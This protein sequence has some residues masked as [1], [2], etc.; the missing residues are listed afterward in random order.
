MA[1]SGVQVAVRRYWRRLKTSSMGTRVAT[2][3]IAVVVI[4][5]IVFGIVAGTSGSGSSSGTSTT[6][7]G[8]GGGTGVPVD[9]ASTSTR[10][11]TSNT[12]TVVF[13]VSNLTALSA[14][15][16]F[17]GDIEYREQ[18]DAINTFV[19]DINNHGGIN[20]RKIVAQIVPFDPTSESDMRARCKDWTE[21]SPVFAV[22]DGLGAWTGDNELCVTQEGSTPFI[23]QWTTVSDWTQ[24]GSPYLWW[25]GPDQSVILR[26]LVAW[27]KSASLLGH[28][29]RVGVVVGDRASDQLALNKY[30][31][32][33]FQQA[34]LPR[35]V[36]QT[37]SA[38]L[39][40][41]A[42]I[43][44]EAPLV[45]QRLRSAGVQSVIP[46]IPFN[47]F[48]PYL[49]AE[50]QQQYFPRLL[51]SDYESTINIALGLIPYPYETALDGQL[52][53]SVETLG[54]IDDPR[55]ESQ[56]GYDAGV[57]SCWDTWKQTH[58]SPPAP[59]AN[60]IE[61]QGPVVSWC[62]AVRLFA[63]AATKAG[64]NLNRRSFVQ[65]LSQITDFPGTLTPTMTFGPNK[66]Y[67]PVEYRVL[68]I[69]N[70]DPNHNACVL[71]SDGTPQGT[72]W[73]IVQDYR[74]LVTG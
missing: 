66:F 5:G 28:G 38:S 44:S 29:K 39:T 45:V 30:L 74:P 64:P 35:P 48:Y 41:T 25:T 2:A 4:G 54:G 22:V 62:Q 20:G 51:L 13:P 58:A 6:V 32:P 57:R 10:G 53:I 37:I 34:G 36:V 65:A 15:E 43:Q 67:G 55:P 9:Q 47:S 17:A 31:L 42:T 8:G 11:V 33:Y 52:G 60:Y 14:Q 23:G 1:R 3:A 7:A 68:R 40:D 61:E 70:N 21:G 27:G 24:R 71:K 56:G 16:G 63:A 12:I 46:L 69:H 49:Q 19:G 26:T 18:Q 73:Q 50:T 59:G 72:C